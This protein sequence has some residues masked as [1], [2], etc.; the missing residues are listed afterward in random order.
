[1]SF[2]RMLCPD[3][4][5]P[6]H[7]DRLACAGGHVFGYD[8]NGVL[9]LLAADFASRLSAFS[10][11]LRTIRVAENR[12]LLDP[13]IYPQLPFAPEVR[14]DH[15]WRLR[16]HDLDV[17]AKFLAGR[18]GLRILDVGAWNGWLSHRL[19]T[20]G[21]EVVAIDYFADAHDGLGARR[22]YGSQW[23]AIQMKLA[24]LTILPASFDVVILNRCLQFQTDPA[25]FV[26]SAARLLSRGG[27][28]LAMG[29]QIFANPDTKARQVAGA[30]AFY[31]ETYDFELFLWPTKGYLDRSDM[32][33]LIDLG[34]SIR[35]Y[36]ALLAAN[37]RARLQPSRPWHGFGIWQPAPATAQYTAL[38]TPP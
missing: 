15:E 5:L 2:L 13:A 24:D 38:A 36:R 28:V 34:V 9:V 33:R 37:L 11:G 8:E 21:H 22:W 6:L 1:M 16:G 26:L 30:L 23:T 14:R 18:T 12:L 27:L 25:A 4:R 32:A 17:V 31:R 10:A 19:S 20:L 29:L 7:S 3:C 35:P